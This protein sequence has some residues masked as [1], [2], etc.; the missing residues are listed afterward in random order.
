MSN[1]EKYKK[2]R[3]YYGMISEE[4]TKKHFL[5][6]SIYIQILFFVWHEIYV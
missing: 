2:I 4:A 1:L 5:R 6:Y 3:R